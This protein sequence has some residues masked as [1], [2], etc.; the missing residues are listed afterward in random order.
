MDSSR[1]AFPDVRHR[2]AT[3]TSWFIETILPKIFGDV[4][5]NSEGSSC[6]VREIAERHVLEDY[7]YNFIPSLQDFLET[8]ELKDWMDNG[9]NGDLPPSRRKLIGVPNRPPTTPLQDDDEY[10]L[11]HQGCGGA[12]MLD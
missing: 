4:I 1:A 6:S 3:H 9:R 10:D 2:A 12:G 8:I 5:K 11:E 7:G